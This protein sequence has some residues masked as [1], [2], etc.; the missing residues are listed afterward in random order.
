MEITWWFSED[1]GKDSVAYRMLQ[2]VRMHEDL[3]AGSD[4]VRWL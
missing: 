1:V 3:W 2:Q 4:D